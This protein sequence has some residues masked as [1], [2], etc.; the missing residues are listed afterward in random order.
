MHGVVP[1]RVGI[2]GGTRVGYTGGLYRG[3]TQ[4][5]QGALRT[6]KRAPEAPA[7]GWSGWYGGRVR[8]APRYHPCGARSVLPEALPVP[9]TLLGQMPPPGQ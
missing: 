2:P 9:G 7:R 5:P 6:A 3:T 8:P 4:L 1:G